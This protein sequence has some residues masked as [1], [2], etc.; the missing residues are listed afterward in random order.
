MSKWLPHRAVGIYIGGVNSPC[1]QPNLRTSWVDREIAAG[2]HLIPLY[3]GLQA[4]R[5]LRLRRD[6]HY[7]ERREGSG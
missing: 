1:S 3:V 6:E 2:W 4:P 7:Q 5:R